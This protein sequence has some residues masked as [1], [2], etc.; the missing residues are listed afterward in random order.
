MSI[1]I[2]VIFIY[3]GDVDVFDSACKVAEGSSLPTMFA[4]KSLHPDDGISNHIMLSG[5]LKHYLKQQ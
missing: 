4:E 1:L 2:I 5:D 3:V